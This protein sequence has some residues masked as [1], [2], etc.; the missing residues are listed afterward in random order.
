M[1]P[2]QAPREGRHAWLST[3]RVLP[4]GCVQTGFLTNLAA[5]ECVKALAVSP[6]VIGQ[7]SLS[8]HWVLGVLTMGLRVEKYRGV[9]TDTTEPGVWV[10]RAGS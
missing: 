7:E 8:I 2:F 9:V 4:E 6:G 10:P 5:A 3:A 1:N